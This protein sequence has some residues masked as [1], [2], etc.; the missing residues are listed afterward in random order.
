MSQAQKI[1]WAPA[2]Q[3]MAA[4]MPAR[5]PAMPG[6]SGSRSM[7]C[8]DGGSSPAPR[9]MQ[10]AA[11]GANVASVC[12]IQV[13]WPAGS[14]CLGVPMRV[15]LPPMRMP[16]NSGVA[17]RE[18]AQ[19][20]ANEGQQDGCAVGI[21]GQSQGDLAWLRAAGGGFRGFAEPDLVG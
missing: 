12:S 9:M 17:A 14:R 5:G 11:V 19:L 18:G 13:C 15:L 2:P 7:C 1:H 8:K 3:R 6:T 10:C 21:P 16:Q 20:F 4:R